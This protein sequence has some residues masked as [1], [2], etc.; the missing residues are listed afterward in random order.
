MGETRI[1]VGGAGF[2]PLPFG[3][4]I[5]LEELE[6]SRRQPLPQLVNHP[7]AREAAEILVHREEREGPGPRRSELLH[8]GEPALEK[9]RAEIAVA[10]ILRSTEGH[11]HG[12]KRTGMAVLRADCF[13]PFAAMTHEVT[14]AVRFLVKASQRKER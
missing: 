8:D 11:A 1:I 3:S 6:Q 2:E 9:Q 14:K 7:V 10:I 4:S 12:P 13:Q 5:G